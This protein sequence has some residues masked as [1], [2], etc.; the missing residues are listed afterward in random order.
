[1]S[2]TPEEVSEQFKF[3]LTQTQFRGKYTEDRL[4]GVHDSITHD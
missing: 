4:S 1:M 3:K 2:Q